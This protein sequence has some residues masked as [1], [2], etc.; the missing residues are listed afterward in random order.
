MASSDAIWSPTLPGVTLAPGRH[1]PGLGAVSVAG[2]PPEGGRGRTQAPHRGTGYEHA[3]NAIQGL[4]LRLK[5]TGARRSSASS[6]PFAPSIRTFLRPERSCAAWAVSSAYLFT[7][8]T[9][10]ATRAKARGPQSTHRL[11]SHAYV[12]GRRGKAV[13]RPANRSGRGA[14]CRRK[15][16]EAARQE[17]TRQETARAV[18]PPSRRLPA[19]YERDPRERDPAPE[20]HRARHGGP[21]ETRWRIDDHTRHAACRRAARRRA[22]YR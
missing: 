5:G 21:S 16:Q 9:R 13:T 15:V 17:A 18:G 11:L 14:R 6:S 1:A 7:F 19:L 22:V 8:A 4:R 2:A 10:F 12:A 3:E 20:T